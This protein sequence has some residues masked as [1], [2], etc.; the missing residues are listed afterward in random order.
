M[1]CVGV[2]DG[3]EHDP[4]FQAIVGLVDYT[5]LL[6]DR[7]LAC[8]CN[9]ISLGCGKRMDTAELRFVTTVATSGRV[10]LLPAV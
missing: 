2:D 9:E 3:L 8:K 10:K 1:D 5:H 6:Q 7:R 4:F